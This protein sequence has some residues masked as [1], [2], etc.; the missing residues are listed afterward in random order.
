M[1]P[2]SVSF[3][4][5]V[6]L[7]ALIYF[8]IPFTSGTF[9]ACEQGFGCLFEF[10]VHTNLDYITATLIVPMTTIYLVP[11]EKIWA[12]ME[13]ILVLL[14]LLIISLVVVNATEDDIWTWQ[15]LILASATMIPV[16]YWIGY[17]IYAECIAINPRRHFPRYHW[18]YLFYGVSL[19]VMGLLIFT[20]Q[21]TYAYAY[22]ADL[23]AL[24]HVFAA[25]G[26]TYII[27]SRAPRKMTYYTSPKN[28]K[29]IQTKSVKQ[30]L[31]E[32]WDLIDSSKRI[33]IE[34]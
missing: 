32:Q 1:A 2:A 30:R 25:F 28:L 19:T 26:Q 9:H 6:F 5:G 8:G 33:T 29:Y 13:T 23:H 4:Y 24:W 14:Y 21:G 27:K 31:A 20:T 17:Y 34:F 11:W 10:V 3:S 15:A 7:Y 18:R 22:V 16:V 12:P